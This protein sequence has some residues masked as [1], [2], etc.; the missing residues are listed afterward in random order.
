MR[1]LRWAPLAL[2]LS[3]LADP[4]GAVV[5]YGEGAQVIKGVQLL[6]DA[7]DANV[8]HYVPQFPRLSTRDDGSLEIL[9]L[10]YV[11]PAG[12]PNGGLFHALVEFSLPPDLV[13]ELERELKKRVAGAR[14]AGPVPLLQAVD[15]GED[16][17]G[18]FQ[19]ISGVLKD[20]DKGGFAQSVVTSGR[21]PLLPGSKAV[22]A[23]ILN[24]QGATLLWESL[25]GPTS[26][27]SVAIHASYE[28]LV[29]NYNARVTADV[30]TVYKHFSELA[31]RQQAYTRRQ[32][33]N[34]VDDLQRRGA[35]KVEVLDQGAALGLKATE[36]EGLLQV[37]TSK[38]TETMFDYK[39]GWS[40]DPARETAVESGQIQGRQSRGWLGRI[41]GGGVLGHL[42]GGSTDSRYYTDDQYVLKNRK[43]IRHNVFSLVLA[44]S[45]TIRVPVDTAGNL[46]GLYGALRED[47]RYFRVVSLGDPAFEFRTVH[48]QV[49]GEY[50]DSFQ[51][52]VN[53]VSVNLRKTYPGQPAFTRALR[54][55]PTDIKAG[56]TVQELA[57]PRLGLT[58]ADWA[59]YE[60]QVRWSLRDGP[61]VSVPPQEDRWL[62]ASDPAVSLLPPFERKVIEIES[63]RQLFAAS[64]VATAV[65]E[66]ATLLGGTPRL[67]P[68]ATLR[69][70]DAAPTTKLSL[71][72]D[73]GTP[74]AVRVSWHSA[75]GKTV[76]RLQPLD[77]SLLYVTPP[78][79]E[80]PGGGQ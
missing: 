49:D 30:T 36:M 43:D 11:D 9:C 58:A 68:R 27:V 23:A 73:R 19:V 67:V 42:Y 65:V 25:T 7:R 70:T 41:F 37:V 79:A 61:T 74:V 39:A 32:I 2:C 16:G 52:T 78:R 15:D 5:R 40:A 34:V 75:A 55:T 8:Y 28:A 29:P 51:D 60:Y 66:F 62:R 6:Q 54:F 18:S 10:K 12:T 69:A 17:V 53:F 45:S 14:I 64:G 38:L 13:A 35:L 1:N 63:D 21:A 4:S 77:S 26:D 71:Y 20:K 50:V 48:F 3:L 72:H 57:L 47:P 59:Q 22:V 80:T 76:G 31:N 46:G 24:Q 56:K 44:K 33:R